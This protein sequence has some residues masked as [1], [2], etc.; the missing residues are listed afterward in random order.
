MPQISKNPV[1]K[2]VFY[3]IRDDFLWTLGQLRSEEEVKS[4]FYDFFTK[5][6]RVMLAKR[7][8]IAMMIHKGFTYDDI[9]FILHVSTSTIT[10][11]S[12]WLDR[13]GV[14]VK[15][16]LDKLVKEEHAEAFWRKVNSFIEHK[17]IK[18]SMYS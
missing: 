2:D 9:K 7:L 5:T 17:F 13:G 10:S 6:E 12:H 14:G 11:V 3:E 1:H 18:P 15:H 8:A 16:I 4:F